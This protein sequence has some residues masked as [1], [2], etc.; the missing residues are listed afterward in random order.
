VVNEGDGQSRRDSRRAEA[1]PARYAQR[2]GLLTIG[3]VSELLSISKATLYSWRTRKPGYGPPA[4]KFGRLLRYRASDVEA[5]AR[6]QR[7]PNT[8]PPPRRPEVKNR[9][10][11]PRGS[12]R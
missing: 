7:D 4:L 11:A 8:P 10:S 5:W 2:D 12:R 6:A 3:Q 9:K 1:T